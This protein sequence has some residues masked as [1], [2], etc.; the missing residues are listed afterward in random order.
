MK[1]LNN[2]FSSKKELTNLL[3][4]YSVKLQ[5]NARFYVPFT[6][7][8]CLVFPLLGIVYCIKRVQF[9]DLRII[10]LGSSE[11]TLYYRS[12]NYGTQSTFNCN[13]ENRYDLNQG[14]IT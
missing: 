11:H 4:A 6:T 9:G 10:Y 8:I 1:L 3:N 13:P 14:I 12:L 2:P 7:L 5:K